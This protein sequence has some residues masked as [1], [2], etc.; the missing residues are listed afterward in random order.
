M[1]ASCVMPNRLP[2]GSASSISGVIGSRPSGPRAFVRVVAR[3]SPPPRMR[4]EVRHGSTSFSR[5]SSPIVMR[6]RSPRSSEKSSG[7]TMPVPVMRKTPCGK[8]SSLPQ[9]VDQFLQ[10]ALDP[11]RA[12]LAG[13]DRRGRPAAPRDR[14]TGSRSAVGVAQRNPGTERA[15]S[16][17]DL[18]LRQVERVL[19]LDVPRGDVVAGAEPDD[20]A[21]RVDHQRELR[22][23]HVPA[24][25]ATN[26]DRHLVSRP[27]ASPAL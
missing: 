1:P 21:S 18:G 15:R 7:G 24:A 12:C 10:R 6:T 8:S 17:V 25:V 27:R 2:L 16:V 11:R 4:L 14:S 26:A 13:E 5:V 22:L 9:V 3:R 19:A 23:R 20:L